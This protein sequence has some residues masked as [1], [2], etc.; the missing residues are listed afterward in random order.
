MTTHHKRPVMCFHGATAL[1]HLL[2]VVWMS[3]SWRTRRC[4]PTKHRATLSPPCTATSAR[5]TITIF[6]QHLAPSTRFHGHLI[7]ITML[8]HHPAPSRPA[9]RLPDP[10]NLAMGQRDSGEVPNQQEARME[11]WR[12]RCQLSHVGILFPLWRTSGCTEVLW[13]Q[14]PNVFLTRLTQTC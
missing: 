6:P 9:L 2:T 5:P 3:L 7:R 11:M 12:L 4:T 8:W 10:L 1:S 13:R 14:F